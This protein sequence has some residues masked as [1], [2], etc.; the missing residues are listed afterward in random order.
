MSD[1][2]DVAKDDGRNVPRSVGIVLSFSCQRAQARL[3]SPD[4]FLME[5]TTRLQ[6][7]PTT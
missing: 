6:S 2:P 1:L 7:A 5:L 4:S 3:C